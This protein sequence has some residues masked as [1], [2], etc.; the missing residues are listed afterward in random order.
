MKYGH[1]ENTEDFFHQ[2]G[3]LH[4]AIIESFEWLPSERQVFIK[5]DDL[6]S[7]FLDLP[8]YEALL[9]ATLVFS[10]VRKI[11]FGIDPAQ[12]TL[13]IYD[14]ET[15]SSAT[16]INVVINFSPGGKMEFTCESIEV[17]KIG[18]S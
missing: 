9:P 7:N 2:L 13:K 14:L 5:I 4:D 16:H 1:I 6:N 17:Q 10:N 18:N 8:E 12:E 11:I 3:L 15:K